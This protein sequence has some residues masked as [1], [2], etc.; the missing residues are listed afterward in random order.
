VIILLSEAIEIF[1]KEAL[2]G[3]KTK[4]N[5]RYGFKVFLKHINCE[6]NELKLLDVLRFQQCKLSTPSRR[7]TAL[8]ALKSLLNFFNDIYDYPCLKSDKI[9]VKRPQETPIPHV[10]EEFIFSL[11]DSFENDFYGIRNKALIHFMYCTGSRADELCKVKITDLDFINHRVLI[12]G[13]GS[14]DRTVFFTS[15]CEKHLKEYLSLRKD[16]NPLLFIVHSNNHSKSK[17]MTTNGLRHLLT[18]ISPSVKLSPHRI[19]KTTG[20]EFYRKTKDIRATQDI[21]GHSQVTTTQKYTLNE[22]DELQNIYDEAFCGGREY[23]FEIKKNKRVLTRVKV[24]S[25]DGE[26]AKK[27]AM[28]AKAAINEII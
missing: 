10:S 11:I 6:L 3:E 13:K 26:S 23:T 8:I 1:L 14:K 2:L 22:L 18:S 20:K 21:L 27:H 9:K 4:E 17:Q 24:W 28:A 19:R 16:N 12:H 15:E 25:A 5:Y 7:W